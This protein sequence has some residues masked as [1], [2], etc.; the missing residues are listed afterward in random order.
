MRDFLNRQEE[1][2]GL[3]NFNAKNEQDF[4]NKTVV[5]YKTTYVK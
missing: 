3:K 5:W 1:Q 4:T 2:S